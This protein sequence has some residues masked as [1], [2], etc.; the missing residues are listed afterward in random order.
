MELNRKRPPSDNPISSA[1]K[2]GTLESYCSPAPFF[3]IF[4][5]IFTFNPQ[6]GVSQN[7]AS[8]SDWVVVRRTVFPPRIAS[9]PLQAR[10]LIRTRAT[11]SH[12]SVSSADTSWMMIMVNYAR[13]RLIVSKAVPLCSF[14]LSSLMY[15]TRGDRTAVT[16]RVPTYISMYAHCTK[17]HMRVGWRRSGEFFF[18]WRYI[19]K[20]R[21]CWYVHT[22]VHTFLPTYVTFLPL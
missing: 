5:F 12:S 11:P 1:K 3:Y 16:W 18:F 13:L 15:S 19:E 9:K 21:T 14:E 8:A 17:S 10:Q 22:E 2:M 4:I 6:F 20:L 7:L